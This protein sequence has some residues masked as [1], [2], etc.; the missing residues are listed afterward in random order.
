MEDFQLVP[1]LKAMRMPRVSLLLADDVGLGKTI[2]AGMVL[3][4]LILRRRVRRILVVCPASL[5]SQWQQEMRDKFALDF[6]IVD[7]PATHALQKRL[8]LDANPWR[9]FP[10]AITSFDYLKQA[11]V[12]EQFHTASRPAEGSPHLPWDLLIVDEAHNLAPSS[13]GEDSD[14]SKMLQRITPWFEHRLFLTATPH[15]GHTRSFTGLLECLDP[16]RFTRKSE[17]LTDSEKA[18]WSRWLSD[19][20][21]ARSTPARILPASPPGSCRLCRWS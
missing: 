4:E 6:D 15:N 2:E 11:D 13:L 14:A 9:T 21:R 1:L 16:V 5:R 12:L 3:T 10:R 17:P 20:S 7:R 19:A 8:G 18:A